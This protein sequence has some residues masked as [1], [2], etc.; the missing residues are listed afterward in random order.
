MKKNVHS[1]EAKILR[2]MEWG[3]SAKNAEDTLKK[4]EAN[5]KILIHGSIGSGKTNLLNEL[6][7]LKNDNERF[8]Y[9]TNEH[10]NELTN[11]NKDRLSINGQGDFVVIDGSKTKVDS[12][13]KYFES[14]KS[15]CVI[16]TL[17]TSSVRHYQYG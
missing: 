1:Y 2:L 8:E 11:D 16:F 6:I 12:L 7:R 3:L 14:Y 13:I 9:Y 15:K 17:I 5:G 4:L 10:N